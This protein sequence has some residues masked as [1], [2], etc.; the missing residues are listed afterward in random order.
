[1]RAA[2]SASSLVL[3]SPVAGRVWR[4]TVGGSGVRGQGSGVSQHSPGEAVGGG[5]DPLAVDEGAAAE[6]A[7]I[8]VQADLP[9]PVAS[10]GVGPAHNPSVESCHA[11]NWGAESGGG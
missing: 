5:Q 10:R 7:P 6:V 8:A 2:I 9:G 11:A 4:V 1:M 3:R